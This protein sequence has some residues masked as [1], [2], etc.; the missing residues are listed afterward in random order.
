MKFDFT[1]S[2][3]SNLSLA[4][5]NSKSLLIRS[6]V[7]VLYSFLTCSIFSMFSFILLIPVKEKIPKSKGASSR[8]K[9]FTKKP[10]FSIL[11]ECLVGQNAD[12]HRL[13][14]KSRITLLDILHFAAQ[15]SLFAVS[16]KSDKRNVFAY[17][18]PYGD[19]FIS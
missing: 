17:R 12:D 7:E 18:F 3:L 4:R 9:N 13:I 14:V 8:P 1:S 16:I 6:L 15:W 10:F 19:Y 5:D 2:N 11:R